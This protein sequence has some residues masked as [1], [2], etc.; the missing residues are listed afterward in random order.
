MNIYLLNNFN[1]IS[2][3]YVNL[4]TTWNTFN[5]RRCII[6]HFLG[7]RSLH[8][9]KVSYFASYVVG[10]TVNILYVNYQSERFASTKFRNL[11]CMCLPF[12]SM[13]KFCYCFTSVT[14]LIFTKGIIFT[15]ITTITPSS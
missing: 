9:L 4:L 13:D 15:Q 7:A 14:R 1:I 10:K 3:V 2:G 8:N 11:C 12:I 5:R 6:I